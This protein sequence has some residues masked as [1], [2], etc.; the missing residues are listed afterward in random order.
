[1]VINGTG[2]S[3]APGALYVN[4]SGNNV[5]W[6]GPITVASASQIRA[7][8]PNARM[9]FSSTVL[10]TDVALECTAGN[11]IGDTSTVI[12]FQNTVSMGSFGSFNADGLAVVVL[13]GNT[14]VWG[15]G[16]TVANGTLLV[17]GQLDGGTVTVASAGTL[18]GSGTILGPVSLNGSTLAPGNSIGTLTISNNVTL[19]SSSTNI[20]ELDR[21]HTPNADLLIASSLSL[22]G[23]LTVVNIGPALQA[24]DSFQLYSGAISGAFAATN[25]PALSSTNLYW[26]TSLL[27]SGIIK[28]GSSSSLPPPLLTYSVSGGV[29]NLS[30]PGSYFGWNVQS[31]SANVATSNAWFDIAGSQAATNLSIPVNSALTNVFYRLRSP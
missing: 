9:N 6:A 20:M 22:D 30:W 10:G 12:T 29:L 21:N 8:N 23:T 3:G 31:N 28:V 14:N 11:T 7:V 26:D 15:G 4:S 19:D 24:G 18:G 25:L 1:V 2:I 13:A 16:T 27:N 17:N 5:T